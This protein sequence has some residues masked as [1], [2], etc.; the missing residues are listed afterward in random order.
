MLLETERLLLRP[1]QKPDVLFSIQFWMNPEVTQYMDGPR[2]KKFLINSFEEDLQ[3]TCQP[4]YDLFP[5]AEKQCGQFVKHYGLL[6]KDVEGKAEVEVVHIIDKSYWGK[7]FATEICAA[8]VQYAWNN[9]GLL[10]LIAL[11]DP[12]NVASKRVA[13]KSGLFF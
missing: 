6:D 8:L 13:E 12:K 10:R 4:M 7:G 3:K 9:L 1:L 5:T 2:E 11:I